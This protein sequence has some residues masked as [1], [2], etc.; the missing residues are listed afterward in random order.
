MFVEVTLPHVEDRENALPADVLA[1]VAAAPQVQRSGW[2]KHGDRPWRVRFLVRGP[3]CI[4]TAKLLER[5]LLDLGYDAEASF[6]P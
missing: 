5:E 4:E 3:A 1:L 6:W 2:S